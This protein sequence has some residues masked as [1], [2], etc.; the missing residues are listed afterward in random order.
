MALLAEFAEDD[1]RCLDATCWKTKKTAFIDEKVAEGWRVLDGDEAKSA[2]DRWSRKKSIQPVT[3]TVRVDGETRSLDSL[4]PDTPRILA[5]TYAGPV[6]CV[7]VKDVVADL[8]ERGLEEVACV[9]S[10]E[11]ER[12]AK[13]EKREKT[14]QKRDERRAQ[15]A[16]IVQAAQRL[17]PET[18]NPLDDILLETA[19]CELN[20][21]RITEVAKR[22]ELS[23]EKG[24]YGRFDYAGAVR[25]H[26]EALDAPERYALFVEL[27]LT[28]SAI[29]PYRCEMVGWYDALALAESDTDE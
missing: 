7:E 2:A 27:L 15:M 17:R 10:G 4:S 13:R 9:V 19:L 23:V 24:D 26:A 11:K 28:G 12:D 3:H 18:P 29:S 6:A 1:D 21:D 22:R 25:R 14:R 5:L 16:A 20:L 8:I